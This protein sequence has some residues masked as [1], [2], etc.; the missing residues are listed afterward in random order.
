MVV[1]RAIGRDEQ[2]VSVTGLQDLDQTSVDMMTLLIVG[3]TETRSSDGYVYTPRGYG[4]KGD[5]G[6]GA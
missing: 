3:S 6:A 4:M 1:A 2:S 5:S